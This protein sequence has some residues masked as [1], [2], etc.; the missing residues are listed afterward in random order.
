[1]RTKNFHFTESLHVDSPGYTLGKIHKILHGLF[2][3][4]VNMSERVHL[5]FGHKNNAQ[6][7][8]P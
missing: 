1:M 2:Q 3:S 5:I 7:V 8:E 6:R 4:L